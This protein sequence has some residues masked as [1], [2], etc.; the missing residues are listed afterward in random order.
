MSLLA[1]SKGEV[2]Y[3]DISSLHKWALV[4]LISMGS[5]IIYA[6]MYLKNVFYDPL[7]QALG[8][9]NADLGLMVSAYGLAAMICYLPSG[10]VADKFRMRTLATVGFLT[11]AVLV[12]VYATLPSVEVCFALFVAMGITSILI[13]WGTRF[14]VVR[15]CCE[16]DEYASKIGI[17]YSIY[18]VTGLVIGLINAGIIAS[19]ANTAVGVQVMLVFL[20]V[21]IAV[22]G[23]IAFFLIPDFKGEIDK[24]A[25]LFSLS[26][27][28]EA[29]KHPGVMWACIA[30]FCVYAV[31][32]GATY[33]TPYL[34][35]CFDADGNLVNVVGL[36]RTY[37]I[38]LLAG[39]IVGY[40]ATK[41]KSP[42][43][44][45]IGGFILSI[46]VLVAFIL[47]P[48]GAEGAM[49]ASILVVI[50]GFTTYGA[51][52]IGSSPLSEV[53]IPMRIFG[54]AAGLLS[55]IGFLP[56]VFIHTWYG[57]MIDA[58]GTAAFTGIFGF[59]ILFTVIGAASLFM[60][61]RS[62]KKHRN[63]IVADEVAAEIAAD[64]QAEE[65][66]T[67]TA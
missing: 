16:E 7:M 56:D 31:Y 2:T 17:S 25:K 37:G 53:K 52:S 23:I 49:I 38:G 19:I 27:A 39:P 47:Y 4:I 1:K 32:Q 13:W 64:V 59:E 35:Q 51:F 11:T 29:I 60:L 40:I 65:S 21:T 48:H 24:E 61:L 55:V 43:K 20:A 66:K 34:T 14:K 28:L 5:S 62:I 41:I 45:I 8:C 3:R 54:T 12:F 44:T 67:A 46:A 30:Y 26:E 10:I 22:L 63:E 18:G 42:S 6:P 36:I 50:F 15:L 57:S 9:T 33:T 58:Q